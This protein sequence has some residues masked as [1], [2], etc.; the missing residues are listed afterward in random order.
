MAFINFTKWS[1][2]KEKVF[3]QQSIPSIPAAVVSLSNRCSFTSDNLVKTSKIIGND[4]YIS[5]IN[6]VLLPVPS[7][8][9]NLFLV[10]CLVWQT[11]K[12]ILISH[13]M[14]N[15][16]LIITLFKLPL[17]KISFWKKFVS[18]RWS[19]KTEL[20]YMPA[21]EFF[22][23]EIFLNHIFKLNITNFFLQK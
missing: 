1:T 18:K 7:L 6:F 14:V 17:F 15:L 2:Q 20:I 12:K 19:S 8:P 22:M 4:L 11:N 9:T 3:N 23:Y 21:T 10:I 16:C 5:Y 13:Y